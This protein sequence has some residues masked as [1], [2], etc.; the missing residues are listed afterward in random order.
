MDWLWDLNLI[1]FFNFYLW[2][3]FLL[4]TTMR[5]RQYEAIVRLVRAVPERWPRLLK[6]VKEHHAIFLTGTTVLP[7]LLA[8]ALS[9]LN[10]AACRYV[11]PSANLTVSDLTVLPVGM[12]LIAIF[13]SAMVAV[14]SYATFR[15]G[16]VDRALLEQYFDQAE[17]WLRSWVAPVVHVFTLGYINPRKMVRV[18][19]Q[20][21]LVQA[22][23]LLNS[24]LWWVTAQVSLRIAFGLALWLTYAWSIGM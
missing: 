23:Q 21:A 10:T 4:S 16:E 6:L 11:W 13:G 14:D 20:K 17:Y 22:S 3:L 18:E 24:T 9:V 2:S 8:L 19:V 1:H 7:A 5:I 12:L 15:V